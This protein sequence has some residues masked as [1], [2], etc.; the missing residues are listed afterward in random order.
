M[1]GALLGLWIALIA[2]D[3]IDLL[4]DRGPFILTPFLALTPLVIAAELVR[5]RMQGRRLTLTR[6][7]VAYAAVSSL[8]LGA[9]LASVFHAEDLPTSAARATLLVA[10]VVSTFVVAVV[11]ADRDDL[12]LVLARGAAASF[13]LFALFDVREAL[14]FIGRGPESMRLGSVLLHFDALQNA[15]P[16]PRLAG[17]VGDGNRAG[18]VLVFYAASIAA[19]ERRRWLRNVGLALASIF[20]LVTVS[21]SATMAAVATFG[22]ASLAGRVRIAPAAV[23]AVIVAF[24]VGTVAMLVRPTLV[25]HAAYALE[26]PLAER[27]STNEGSAEGHLELI[28]RGVETASES[29]PRAIAGV[30][31]GNAYRVLQDIFPGNRYGNFHSLYVTML[32][33]SGVFALILTLLLFAVPLSA[34][35]AWRPLVAGAAAFNIFYQATA[36]PVFWFLLAFAWLA[37][38]RRSVSAARED[39][40]PAA[41]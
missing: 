1:S 37:M 12:S 14:W 26:S 8:L 19:G 6:S 18:F 28:E 24:S 3:R 16:L 22:M 20:F 11:C 13:V 41:G 10:D 29:V 2:A 34:G 4:G 33:E 32:A 38:P 7:A 21:R 15:G 31:F 40:P 30:G 27:V 25:S 39:A 23:L 9:V 36:E 35:G 17:P 5:R